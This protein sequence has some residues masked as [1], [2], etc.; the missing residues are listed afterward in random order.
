MANTFLSIDVIAR[1]ALATLYENAVMANLVHRDVESDFSGTV[2]GYKKGNTV[3]V[4]KPAT[5]DANEYNGSSITVQDATETEVAVVLNH[6]RD[7]SF[8]VTSEEMTLEI[9]EF[10]NRLIRPAMEA[11]WQVID[12]DLIGLRSD[13]TTNTQGTDG[14]TPTDPDV[15]IDATT[16]LTSNNVP[17]TQRYGVWSAQAAGE[18]LKDP[19]FHQADQRG[20]TDGLREA[21][22]GRKFG[23]DHFVDQNIGAAGSGDVGDNLV[24]HRSAFALAMRPLALPRG[25]AEAVNLSYKGLTLRAVLDYDM[26][27]K[28]DTISIDA[29]YGVK[30]LDE[31][32]ACKVLG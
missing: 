24:F 18:F 1:E 19:L 3:N 7:V 29:L 10:S 6:H 31:T 14:T 26:D 17:M 15:I 13:V 28:S 11:I 4:R 22:I 16:D 32:R 25:A 2:N 12:T 20:D 27:T 9:D 23:A 5:F 8:A 21:S 30:T